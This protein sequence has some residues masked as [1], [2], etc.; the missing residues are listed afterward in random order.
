[1]ASRYDLFAPSHVELDLMDEDAVRSYISG[2]RIDI[3]IHA[4]AKP[5]HRNAKD[6][7]NIF[8]TNTRMFFNLARNSNAIDKMI[9]IGSG[10]I[11]DN[12]FYR[13]KML[14][15]YFDEHVPIDEHGL[16]KYVIEKYIERTN[17]IYDLR[18]FG[19]YGRYEDYSIR[20]ISNMICKA[21]FDLPLTINQDRSFDYLWVD[22]LVPILYHV[23]DS[24]LPWPSM[25]ITPGESML[26]SAI[27][28]CVLERVGKDLPIVIKNSGIGSEYSGNNERLNNII[29][30]FNFTQIEVGIDKLVY[31][32][33]TI[34]DSI[35]IENLRIDR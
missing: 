34:K 33:K 29:P 32:Y 1:M 28:Q 24:G 2:K 25:N 14:E 17:N 21:L 5:G 31:Y 26:L 23:I 10:A 6:P 3:I 18:I 7:T 27:A 15:T 22:D 13:A 8:Y 12:R 20:F 11:Y 30:N 35:E 19:I 16:S 4:A 9:V